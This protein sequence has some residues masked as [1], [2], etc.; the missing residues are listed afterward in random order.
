MFILI[1]CSLVETLLNTISNCFNDLLV[2]NY[3]L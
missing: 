2:L 1:D 3:T